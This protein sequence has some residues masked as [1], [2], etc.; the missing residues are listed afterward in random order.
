MPDDRAAIAEMHRALRPGGRLL[1]LDHV[2]ASNAAVRAVQRLLEPVTLRV[3][4]DYLTRRPLPLVQQAGFVIE[5]SGR[6][7]AGMVEW[8]RAT[9]PVDSRSIG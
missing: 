9:R 4:A 7:G 3:G 1:L 8:L 5:E 2:V 6:A